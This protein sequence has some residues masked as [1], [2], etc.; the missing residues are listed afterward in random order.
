[1]ADKVGSVEPGKLADMVVVGENPVQNLKVLYGT[2][3][4]KLND[5]N[6]VVRVG[7]SATRSRTASS[8]T[9]RSCSPTCAAS[10]ARRRTRKASPPSCN[11]DTSPG[12]PKPLRGDGRP[13]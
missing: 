13:E 2:G 3:A 8:T 10:C 1:M 11:P 9:R 7:G 4:V 12:N 6:D 5:T